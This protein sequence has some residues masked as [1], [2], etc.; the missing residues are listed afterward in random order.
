[1][2]LK[3]SLAPKFYTCVYMYKIALYANKFEV[4]KKKYWGILDCKESPFEKKVHYFG[5]CPRTFSPPQKKTQ[6]G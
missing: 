4:D 1:M 2:S 5:K 3:Y 6:L